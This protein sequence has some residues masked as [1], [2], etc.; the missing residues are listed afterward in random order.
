MV[1]KT[2]FICAYAQSRSKWFAEMYMRK[3]RKAMFA[4]WCA[5]A[6]FPLNAQHLDWAD[7]IVFLDKVLSALLVC[8]YYCPV[9]LPPSI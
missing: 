8:H 4:G 7:E 1:T 2:L 9:F 6:D 5:D 3:G